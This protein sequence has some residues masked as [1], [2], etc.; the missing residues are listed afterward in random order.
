MYKTRGI[1]VFSLICL[2]ILFKAVGVAADSITCSTVVDGRCITVSGNLPNVTRSQEVTILVGTKENIIYI[3]QKKSEADGDFCFNFRVPESLAYGVYDLTIGNDAKLGTYKGTLNYSAPAVTVKRE[4]INADVNV[5]ISNYIPN[6]SGT[7]YCL[8]NKAIMLE[9]LNKTDNVV[10][11]SEILTS[12][13]GVFNL[14]YTLPSLL[15]PKEYEIIVSCVGTS[16][17]AEISVLIDSS[18]LALEVNGAVN[19]ADN[20]IVDAQLQSVNTGLIDKSTSFTGNKSVSATIPNLVSNASFH[21]VAKGYETVSETPMDENWTSCDVQKT[22]DNA[23]S[24]TLNAENIQSFDDKVFVVRYDKNIISLTSLFG[25]EYKNVL[26]T[27][28]RGN[29][30]ITSYSPGEIK[31]KMVNMSVPENK[32]WSGVMNVFKFKFLNEN[33]GTSKFVMY[34]EE[35]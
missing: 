22:N 2:I 27:G 4:F 10:I 28:T 6:I 25:T 1:I 15:N 31:F 35:E 8:H 5:A 3:N 33:G 13:D 24:V 12:E 23:F 21:L 11:A 34:E 20:V 32:L 26:Q 16:Q 14:S 29:V 19:T 30:N 18:V 17:M 9:L 7:L